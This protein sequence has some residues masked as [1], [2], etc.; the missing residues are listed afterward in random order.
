MWRGEQVLIS[1]Y[2]SLGGERYYD[3]ESRSSFAFDH[4]TQ[5]RI[6]NALPS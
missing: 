5:V 2:N 6:A 3:G 1:A 4:V